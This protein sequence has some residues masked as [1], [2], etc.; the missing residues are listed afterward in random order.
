M[1]ATDGFLVYQVTL[2]KC[3]YVITILCIRLTLTLVNCVEK[4]KHIIR[5]FYRLVVPSL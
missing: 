2:Y 4:T 5:Q 1:L 3:L